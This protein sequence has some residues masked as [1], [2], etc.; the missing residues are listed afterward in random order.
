MLQKA[1]MNTLE[2]KPKPNSL[3]NEDIKKNEMQIL[4]LKNTVSEMQNF[5]D[6]LNRRTEELR[7][8]AN[9]RQNNRNYSICKIARVKTTTTKKA[10]QSHRDL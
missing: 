10:G 7:K 3:N 1:I 2:I 5:T 8:P 6:G 9:L 4:E